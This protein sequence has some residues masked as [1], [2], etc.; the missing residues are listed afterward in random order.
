[1][2]KVQTNFFGGDATFIDDFK[3]FDTFNEALDF[4]TNNKPPDEFEWDVRENGKGGA[5]A[6]TQYGGEKVFAW[7]EGKIVILRERST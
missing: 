2:Y 3:D 7:I 5:L 6:W 1:M 4:I